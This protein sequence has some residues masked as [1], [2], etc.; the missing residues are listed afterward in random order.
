[1]AATPPQ[2]ITHWTLVAGARWFLYARDEPP[3]DAPDA[4]C[5]ASPEARERELVRP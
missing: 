4:T 2:A 1:M 3:G 5:A